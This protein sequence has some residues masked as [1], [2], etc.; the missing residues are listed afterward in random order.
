MTFAG[1]SYMR[2]GIPLIHEPG[3]EEGGREPADPIDLRL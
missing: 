1:G 3:T 2:I